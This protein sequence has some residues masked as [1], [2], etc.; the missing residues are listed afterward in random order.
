MKN[1]DFIL[2]PIHGIH[3]E[4]QASIKRYFVFEKSLFRSFSE[5]FVMSSKK[6]EKTRVGKKY[7]K[8][9]KGC[10]LYLKSFLFQLYLDIHC[11]MK[12]LF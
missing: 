11:S 7:R 12:H 8:P 4:I 10:G 6:V 5:D 9:L 3:L 2:I 1:V